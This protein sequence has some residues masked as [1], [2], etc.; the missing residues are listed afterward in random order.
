MEKKIVNIGYFY[1]RATPCTVLNANDDV[2]VRLDD[3]D[4]V[5]PKR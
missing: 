4:D 2:V 3:V 5:D 1:L